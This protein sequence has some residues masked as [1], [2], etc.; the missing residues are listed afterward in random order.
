LEVSANNYD[1]VW[2]A[3]INTLR[4]RK[5]KFRLAFE[6]NFQIGSYAGP[7]SSHHK[8]RAGDP[9]KMD[10]VVVKLGANH[11]AL[12]KNAKSANRKKR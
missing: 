8:V 2:P 4:E 3:L 12:S 7:G 10:A 9:V 11:S 1:A 5:I 6:K